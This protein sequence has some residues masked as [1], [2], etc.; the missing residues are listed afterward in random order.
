MSVFGQV[1]AFSAAA[2][3]LGALLAWFFLARPA[4]RRVHE[5]RREQREDGAARAR[6]DKDTRIA[7]S[8]ARVADDKEGDDAV[9]PRP[10]SFVPTDADHTNDAGSSHS[11]APSWPEKD[12][13]RGRGGSRRADEFDELDAEFA[14]QDR[15]E[16]GYPAPPEVDGPT[17][18]EP[19]HGDRLDVEPPQ[20]EAEAG[21]GGRLFDPPESGGA[22]DSTRVEQPPAYAFGSGR[23]DEPEQRPDW[24]E[25]THVLPKRQP[26][27]SPLESFEQPKPLPPS[28]RP[29]QRRETEG[30]GRSRGGSLFE[31]A[32][33][34][35]GPQTPRSGAETSRPEMPSGPFGPGSAMPRPGGER[36][37]EEYT[38]KA[39]VTALRY[40][41]ESSPEF[42]KMVAEVWFRT[43]E[44]A[45]RVGFRPLNT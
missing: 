37:S 6:E 45:E 23:D 34:V 16:S 9:A 3:V 44:D 38:V 4:Q 20:D 22:D 28:A 17:R 7:P 40:C 13:L 8:P 18:I 21:H 43:P 27:T 35:P 19:R 36:P 15:V 5:L 26:G 42:A 41:D 30:S 31:P 39:S 29:G 10:R 11:A 14:R 2:F 1:W 33:P 24:V 25:H 12:S 32:S